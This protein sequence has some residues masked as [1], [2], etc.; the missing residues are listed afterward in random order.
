[1]SRRRGEVWIDV[2]EV[3]RIL[4]HLIDVGKLLATLSHLLASSRSA[5]V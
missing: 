5:R 3:P 2:L 4:T 1:M